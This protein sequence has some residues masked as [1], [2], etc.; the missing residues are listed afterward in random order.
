VFVALLGAALLVLPSS[1]GCVD[2]ETRERCARHHDDALS[3]ERE[4]SCA[5]T[6][7]LDCVRD[8]GTSDGLCAAACRVAMGGC[9]LPESGCL[10]VFPE[11]GRPSYENEDIVGCRSTDGTD[12]CVLQVLE[13]G[14]KVC[15]YRPGLDPC[16]ACR[17]ST[18]GKCSARGKSTFG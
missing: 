13:G 4:P 14:A 8:A 7:S 18:Q 11:T 16:G 12:R 3:C 9:A 1:T 5:F 17:P 10:A 2:S 6:R 15:R